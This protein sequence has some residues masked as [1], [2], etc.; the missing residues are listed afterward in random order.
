MNG[1]FDT[2][3][4]AEVFVTL[5]VIMDPLGNVPIFL[6]LTQGYGAARR[7][8]L[9][10][11]SVVVAGAVIAVF[12]LIG[13]QILEYLGISIAALEV[14]GGLILLLVSVQLLMGWGRQPD[15]VGEV[16]VALVPLGTPLIAG[17]GAIAATM[18][19]VR[20]A[21]GARDALAIAAALA[22]VLVLL[23]LALRF[24]STLLRLL[25]DSG[26][27]LVTRIAGLLLSAIAIQ[28]MAEGA[29][30]FA[31]LG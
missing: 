7:R 20:Q 13:K 6:S 21:H 5:L 31:R 26:I 4:F 22:C 15:Q 30:R 24:S 2:H 16:N 9:A 17:P 28:L 11:E 8:R 18:V 25:H 19:F 1:A 27:H 3:L 12:A 29:L 14:S 23:W 10:W